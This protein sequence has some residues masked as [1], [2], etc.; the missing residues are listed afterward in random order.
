MTGRVV[1]G[2]GTAGGVGEDVLDE[3]VD[4][5]TE[6]VDRQRYKELTAGRVDF[7]G[8]VLIVGEDL[9]ERCAMPHDRREIGNMFHRGCLA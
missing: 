1:A 9:P 6:I 5:R 7:G 3:N 2:L 4:C 8:A